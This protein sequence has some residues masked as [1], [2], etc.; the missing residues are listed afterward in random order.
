MI[1]SSINA[2]RNNQVRIHRYKVLHGVFTQ[3]TPVSLSLNQTNIINTGS[4]MTTNKANNK[5]NN[6]KTRKPKY[7]IVGVGGNSDVNKT[8]VTKMM[9]NWQVNPS[10]IKR[11]LKRIDN[12]N[13][14]SKF[15][16]SALANATTKNTRS[17]GGNADRKRKR[18]GNRKHS[19]ARLTNS[20]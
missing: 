3:S 18:G 1:K 9:I 5:D 11:T 8:L 14:C 7:L 15:K 16:T 20:G 17:E 13:V 19:R 10:L 12:T 2:I 6:K 4:N